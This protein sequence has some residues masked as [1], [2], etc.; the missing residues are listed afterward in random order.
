M[1]RTVLLGGQKI[2][3]MPF[4]IVDGD[5]GANYPKGH[6][7][8]D[9]GFCLF[10]SAKN[11]TKDGFGF[12][13]KQF[14]TAQKDSL[15]RKGKLQRDDVVLTTRGTV[16]NVA[17]YDRS[18]PYDDVRINSG[19]VI[20]RC[21]QTKLL[22]KYL[23]FVLKSG[24]FQEQVTNF[25]SG[26]AQPQLPI[27]DMQNMRLP[28]PGLEEQRYIINQ[29]GTIDEKIELN[30]KMN[31]TLEK[32]GQAL[33]R[34]YFIDNPEAEKVT[35]KELVNET[36]NR[37]GNEDQT[38]YTILSAVK[39]GKLVASEDYFTKQ[40]FSKDISKYK[41][42]SYAE[43]AYNPAR[44]NIGSIG[45]LDKNI[46]GAVSPVYVTFKTKA[47]YHN[48]INELLKLPVTKKRIVD[49]CS[50]TVRQILRFGDFQRIGTY[51]I[52]RESLLAF[53]E[54]YDV[55]LA[56]IERNQAEIQTLTALRD[57]LLPRLISGKV[58]V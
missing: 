24:L 23:Y 38:K 41:R 56:E 6:E 16:G 28:L 8:F 50:G 35:I 48:A 34:H 33:F 4:R 45:M 3:D 57:T 14:I 21:D 13:Q 2:K 9:F 49:L 11:V 52:A 55:F 47:N 20:I 10:L 31:E 30:R 19:M 43:F 7:F 18:V 5:R 32:M 37:V 29:I 26:S 22:P 54:E 15:L 27:R 46:I 36:S 1:T 53:N 25:S 17:L 12:G 42:V 40:V 44:V 39:T 51:K 58:K